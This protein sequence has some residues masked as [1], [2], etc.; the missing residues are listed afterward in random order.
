MIFP[1][2]EKTITN[3]LKR[4]FSNCI[5]LVLDLGAHV[6]KLT[7]RQPVSSTLSKTFIFFL[8]II[9]SKLNYT[10]R[11]AYNSPLFTFWSTFNLFCKK[12]SDETNNFNFK[13]VIVS[14]TKFF[15]S[16]EGDEYLDMTNPLFFRFFHYWIIHLNLKKSW[17][18]NFV[19]LENFK[20]TVIFNQLF[21]HQ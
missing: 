5:S 19:P 11:V 14:V 12:K 1:S 4:F 3:S 9:L 7:F 17:S 2:Q 16:I 21:L 8:T 13:I 18:N 15:I 6:V 10:T 20:R